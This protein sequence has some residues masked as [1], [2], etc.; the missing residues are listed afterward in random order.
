MWHPLRSS[1]RLRPLRSLQMNRRPPVIAAPLG[2]P[3]AFGLVAQ[4]AMR[5]VAKGMQ[6]VVTRD[7]WFVALRRLD[8]GT[9]P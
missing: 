2:G 7:E 3:A 9:L 8:A 5:L 4:L 1:R 6:G